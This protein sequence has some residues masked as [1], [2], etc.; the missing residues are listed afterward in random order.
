[1]AKGS[2]EIDV[3]LNLSER[4][5]TKDGSVSALISKWGIWG[6]IS[7]NRHSAKIGLN[8]VPYGILVVDIPVDG[9]EEEKSINVEQ[10]AELLKSSLEVVL[11]SCNVFVD[12]ANDDFGDKEDSF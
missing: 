11:P 1:M 5:A 9:A 2:N 12:R 10:V 8:F 3:I 7:S 6:D 4:V